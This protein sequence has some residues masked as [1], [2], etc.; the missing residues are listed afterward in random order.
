MSTFCR[1]YAHGDPHPLFEGPEDASRARAA[2]ESKAAPSCRYLV[3]LVPDKIQVANNGKAGGAIH[4]EG[5]RYE[6]A[7]AAYQGGV[8]V[9]IA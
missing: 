3:Y 4:N 2:A 8:E 5:G 9:P 1:V 7:L 6:R